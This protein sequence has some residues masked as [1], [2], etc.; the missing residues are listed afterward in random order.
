MNAKWCQLVIVICVNI[1]SGNGLLLD[2]IK[3]L[4]EP[5]LTYHQLSFVAFTPEQFTS[6]VHQLNPSH[7]FGG[8]T[9]KIITKSPR[10]QWDK[11]II[12]APPVNQEWNTMTIFAYESV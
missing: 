2:G 5:M 10:G 7:M 6:S 11:W 4:H 3:P 12:I 8:Y 1:G 9:F